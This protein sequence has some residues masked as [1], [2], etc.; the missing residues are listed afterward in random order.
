MVFKVVW[1][2]VLFSHYD[3]TSCPT[4]RL[5]RWYIF[6]SFGSDYGSEIEKNSKFWR[7]PNPIFSR[8]LAV[9]G[10][11][12]YQTVIKIHQNFPSNPAD[13]DTVITNSNNFSIS[14]LCVANKCY[15]LLMSTVSELVLK[16]YHLIVDRDPTKSNTQ[17]ISPCWTDG[18]ILRSGDFRKGPS[19]WSLD[20]VNWHSVEHHSPTFTYVA[21]FI[22]IVIKFLQGT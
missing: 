19:P 12:A 5:L 2:S 22:R 8:L 6:S 4:R 7:Q 17:K 16:S 1:S 10:R 21:I 20:R 13:T 15:L 18:R 3:S 11:I 14:M 9:I